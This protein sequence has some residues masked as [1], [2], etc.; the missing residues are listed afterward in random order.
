MK[1]GGKYFINL[2]YVEIKTFKWQKKSLIKWIR[3][4]LPILLYDGL[5]SPVKN[6]LSCISKYFKL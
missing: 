3:F 5:L 2:C 1:I 6:A 4:E